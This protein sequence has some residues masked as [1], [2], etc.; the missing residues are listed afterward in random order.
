MPPLTLAASS[1]IGGGLS[2]LGGLSANKTSKKVAREQMAFQERMSNTA[3]QRS[4]ADMRTAGLNPLLAYQKGGASTPS[5][6]QP[7]IRNPLEGANQ[8]ASNYITAKM[9]KANINNVNATTALTLEKANTEKL[10]QLKTAAD[11]DLT[12]ERLS[13]QQQ[14]T[15]QEQT[16]VLTAIAQLGTA[17][18]TSK[19]AEATADRMILQGNI[20]RSEVGQWLAYLQRAKELGLGLD[21][22]AQILSRRKPGAPFPRLPTRSD[23][24]IGKQNQRDRYDVIE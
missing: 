13:T 8:A 22:V 2:F 6:A 24:R 4:M 1:L 10:V 7:N 14:L 3:Y 23:T 5:G 18:M 15:K 16:R 11:T 21:T 9:A 12:T 17:R 20:D 19:Q